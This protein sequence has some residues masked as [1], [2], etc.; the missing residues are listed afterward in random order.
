MS[1][2]SF[3]LIELIVVIAIVAILA[4]IVAPNAFRAVE[5]AKVAR[6]ISD[7]KTLKA[8][9]EV[10]YA[11]NGLRPRDCHICYPGFP[12]D[13]MNDPGVTYAP[14]WDGPYL[15]KCAFNPYH[16]SQDR[17]DID[18]YAIIWGGPGAP[19][20]TGGQGY[21]DLDGDAVAEIHGVAVG[22]NGL[23]EAV[24]NRVDLMIDGEVNANKG[25]LTTYYEGLPGPGWRVR[26]CALLLDP[27][28]S[29]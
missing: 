1:K 7:L 20:P 22:Y 17:G 21:F 9:V 8:A 2:N 23:N 19:G 16:Q 3:T 26:F 27:G 18:L 28:T 5:K 13:L 10:Y 4:A 14:N 12:N 24:A 11:D 29:R 15:E 25:M 6:L